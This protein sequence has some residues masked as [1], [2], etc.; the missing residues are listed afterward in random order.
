MKFPPLIKVIG[1]LFLLLFA[2][3]FFLV[4]SVVS[5]VVYVLTLGYVNL[6][7]KF[8]GLTTDA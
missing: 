5:A 4:A 2:V 1:M 8:E 3:L 7:T 6:F